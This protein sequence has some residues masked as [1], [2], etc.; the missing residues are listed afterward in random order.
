MG[1]VFGEVVGEELEGGALEVISE[2]CIDP[3]LR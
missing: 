2:D 3:S 1:G